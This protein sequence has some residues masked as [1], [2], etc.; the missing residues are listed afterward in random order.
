MRAHPIRATRAGK[1]GITAKQSW[2]MAPVRSEPESRQPINL[3]RFLTAPDG[4]RPR[5]FGEVHVGNRLMHRIGDEQ[6]GA[7][8]FVQS[9]DAKRDIHHIADDGVFLPLGGTD[10]ADDRLARVQRDADA[11]GKQPA[12]FGE[13]VDLAQ[14][15]A[16]GGEGVGAIVPVETRAPKTARK[17]SPRNLFTM[18]WCSFTVRIMKLQSVLRQAATS[19]APRPSE[20]VVKLR[21]SSTSTQT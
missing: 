4:N 21:M 2:L 19:S 11:G 17:P 5:D 20:K 12:R 13:F 7:E 15:A 16:R 6:R 9:L 14:D 10:A 8:L 3:Q 1:R 18:P